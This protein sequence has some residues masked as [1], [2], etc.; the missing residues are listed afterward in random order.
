MKNMLIFFFKPNIFFENLVEGKFKKFI[1][2]IFVINIFLSICW[3]LII[4]IPHGGYDIYFIN[5]K[6]FD[7]LF[8]VLLN[9][10]IMFSLVG[11]LFLTTNKSLIAKSRF[12]SSCLLV[13]SLF[14]ISILAMTIHLL[15]FLLSGKI[16]DFQLLFIIITLFQVIYFFIG[17]KNVFGFSI[18]K[19]IYIEFIS[20]ILTVIFVFV[21]L[22]V[23]YHILNI[24]D[25]NNSVIK[26]KYI[27]NTNE[28]V[29]I[30]SHSVINELKVGDKT[31]G[32][33]ESNILWK[34]VDPVLFEDKHYDTTISEN[35]I[36]D[37][38]MP[39]MKKVL[40][41]NIYLEKNDNNIEFI[42]ENI[43]NQI[44]NE[45]NET[46]N[47]NSFNIQIVCLGIKRKDQ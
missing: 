15:C 31:Y 4:G 9:I 16:I 25:S 28:H 40:L 32:L 27:L 45:C 11:G 38:Y 6:F 46:I 5:N 21:L 39:I 47:K 29:K 44:M 24:K 7:A 33:Y 10:V 19:T 12:E 35:R 1:L 14:V 2:S 43:T 8:S 41:E 22:F 36:E 42:D 34:I 3:E 20:L 13:F 30:H 18:L 37:I 23:E 26:E 17:I